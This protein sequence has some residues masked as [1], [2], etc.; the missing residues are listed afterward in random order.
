[1]DAHLIIKIIHMSAVSLLIIAF[2]F[3]ASTLFVGI[4]Q[5]QPNP[6]G[7]K[8]LVGL[9]HL[10]LTLM[11]I[12]GVVLVVMKNFDVEP[13]FYA[14]VILFFVLWSSLIKTYKNDASILLAQ[15]RAGLFIGTV[16]LIGILG[17][18]I[19]KPVFT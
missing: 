18:V 9:Q 16:A 5:Q 17:L 10:A 14:K 1:M 15:R 6:K 19:I 3:R 12:T 7:R 4:Q 2:V 13:W 8:A 11:V